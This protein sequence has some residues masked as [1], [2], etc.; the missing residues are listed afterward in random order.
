MS[1]EA[2]E[3]C[4]PC[5]S[6]GSSAKPMVSCF[7]HTNAD[8]WLT[9]TERGVEVVA[10]AMHTNSKRYDRTV[11]KG[12][13]IEGVNNCL[14]FWIR[15]LMIMIEVSVL[16]SILNSSS[17]SPETF[18]PCTSSLISCIVELGKFDHQHDIQ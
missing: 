7:C 4:E 14:D 3:D 8:A 18:G 2:N 11:S 6:L 5:A 16:N 9:G 1:V 10:P 13:I 17:S 12:R 15:R